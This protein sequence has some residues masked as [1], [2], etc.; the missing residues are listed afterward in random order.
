[1]KTHLPGYDLMKHPTAWLPLLMS[2]CALLLFLT[3]LWILTPVPQSN[4][5]EGIAAHVY[6]MLMS[7]QIP[8]MLLFPVLWLKREPRK[9]LLVLALQAAAWLA[10]FLPVLLS[11]L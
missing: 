9:T 11:E 4:G 3:Y 2:L 10:A 7:L 6:Q 1:M 5:D 8:V